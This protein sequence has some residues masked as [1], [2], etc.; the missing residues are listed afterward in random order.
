VPAIDLAELVR[1]KVHDELAAMNGRLEQLIAGRLVG[2][3]SLTGRGDVGRPP[4]VQ[5]FFVVI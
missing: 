1:R 2:A 4:P 3:V 5:R